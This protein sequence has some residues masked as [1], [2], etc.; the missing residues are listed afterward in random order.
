MQPL[1]EWRTRRA[2]RACDVVGRGVSL[3]GALFVDNR[4]T[5]LLGDGVA[6]RSSPVRSHLVTGPRGRIRIDDGVRLGH[7]V[8]ICSHAAV[9]IGAE[10]IVE[11]FA[12]FLDVDFHGIGDR[13]S[14]GEARPVHVGRRVRIGSGAV[15]LRGAFV[16]DDA[17]VAPNSVVSR[18]VPAGAH[19]GGV[20]A[21]P[22][23]ARR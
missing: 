10:T 18:R 19:V 11:P 20:P 15:L 8:S 2:L 9:W 17:V 16:E 13:R 4:G 21:R 6:I 1:R 3:D 14:I 12:I 7:G 5:I 22:L 23:L